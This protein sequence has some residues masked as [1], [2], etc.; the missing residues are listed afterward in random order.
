[1]KIC[2]IACGKRKAEKPVR[3]EEMYLGTLFKY[4]LAYARKIEADKI[5]I[6][7]AKH[8]LLALDTVIEPYN[9]TLNK[10]RKAEKQAWAHKVLDQ[11][12]KQTNLEDDFFVFLAG[13]NYNEELKKS[14]NYEVPLKGLGIG[15]QLQFL[16][17]NS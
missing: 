13:K 10:K 14:L 2:L 4:S 5:F 6:L 7:S 11:L 16:K 17:K 3:A 9:E 1:M 12:N 8:G 15:K